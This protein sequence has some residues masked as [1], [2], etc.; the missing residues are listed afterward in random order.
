[1]SAARPR[2]RPRTT[3]LRLTGLLIAAVLLADVSVP[4]A[5]AG[6]MAA[7]GAR[8]QTGARSSQAPAAPPVD[9]KLLRV[10]HTRIVSTAASLPARSSLAELLRLVM[11]DADA[12][13]SAG[14]LGEEH[15]ASLVALAFYVNGW[16]LEFLV[17]EARSWPRA[18]RRD[19]V[20]R[21]RHDLAQHFA[22]SAVLAAFAGTS[23]AAMAGLYK[24]MD[25]ARS[26]GSGFSFSDLAADRAGTMFGEMATRSAESARRLQS[27]LGA[28]LAERDIM[29]AVAGL[30]DNLSQ[31]EFTRRFGGVGAP[32][33]NELLEDINR[34]VAALP[35]FQ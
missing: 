31:A 19:I 24:E 20:L 27:R 28:G 21:G 16:P 33:Y 18:A 3:A 5:A 30:P 17:P 29:I 35:L 26:G 22:V 11:Q 12:E 10:Y 15:R 23:V 4:S 8:A 34:R 9:V 25:D 7:V 2:L 13:P 6:R 1:M 32:A 14:R